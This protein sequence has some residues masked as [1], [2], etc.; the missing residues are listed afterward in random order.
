M[1]KEKVKRLNFLAKKSREEGLNEEE[2]TEQKKLRDEY[3]ASVIGNMKETLKHT[4]I[5][6]PDGTKYQPK[7]NKNK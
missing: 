5:E 3:R 4:W 7:E 1:E 2:R 6:R